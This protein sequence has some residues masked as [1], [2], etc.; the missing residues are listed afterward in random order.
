MRIE[1]NTLKY[2]KILSKGGFPALYAETLAGSLA[3]IEYNNLYGKTEINTMLSQA[4]QNTFTES[5]KA[6]REEIAKES[7]AH[8]KAIAEQRREFD[9]RME[10]RRRDF[11]ER[12]QQFEK[13]FAERR[14]ESR[15]NLRW[16]IGT[17]ITCTLALASYT[18]ALIRLTH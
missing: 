17:I 4:I 3:D 11:A 2:A 7:K 13:E 16:I 5:R 15:N 14:I 1:F 6:W 8:D 18:A 10:E 9:A 12:S